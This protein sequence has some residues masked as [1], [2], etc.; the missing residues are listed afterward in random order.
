MSFL[1]P[2]E[3]VLTEEIIDINYPVF[4]VNKR[5]VHKKHTSIANSNKKPTAIENINGKLISEPQHYYEI[6]ISSK[7]PNLTYSKLNPSSFS[8]SYMYLYG[9][10]HNNIAN[11]TDNNDSLVGELVIEHIPKSSLNQ[12]IYTCYLLENR[13]ESYNDLDKLIVLTDTNK[14]ENESRINLNNLIYKQKRCIHYV[15]GNNHVFVFLNPLSINKESSS[16]IKNNL[17]FHTQLF[18]KSA[19]EDITMVNLDRSRFYKDKKETKV[20]SFIGSLFNNK[21]VIEGNTNMQDIYIDCQPVNES[22]ETETAYLSK[23]M[24][25]EDGK[26]EQLMSFYKMAT[27]FV[28]FIIIAIVCRFSIPTMYKIIIINNIVRGID[29]DDEIAYK[30]Y[31]RIADFILIG[32]VLFHLFN[33]WGIGMSENGYPIFIVFFLLLLAIMIFSYSIIQLKKL[34]T[35]YMTVE[36]DGEKISIEYDPDNDNSD[37]YSVFDY[38]SE[39]FFT[40]LSAK[41]QTNWKPLL[42]I[43]VLV[44]LASYLFIPSNVREQLKEK[45]LSFRVIDLINITVVIPFIYFSY[46]GSK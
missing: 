13:E 10:I 7:Q 12:K 22:D 33:F 6:N 19:P 46:T 9:V 5:D 30:M 38:V 32:I 31:I 3:M 36:K 41:I 15:S 35:E 4:E 24:N 25:S 42:F 27:N 44:G 20:E 43:S 29:V 8:S 2:D 14:D 11:I 16:Y 17:A 18:N 21:N 39:F 26:Q 40:H 1:Y 34:D 28:L 37:E 23:I 45:N